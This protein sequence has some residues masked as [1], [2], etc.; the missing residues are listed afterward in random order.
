MIE[1]VIKRMTEVYNGPRTIVKDYDDVL[2]P[3]RAANLQMPSPSNPGGAP[4]VI[5]VDYP[6]VEEVEGLKRDGFYDLADSG[7]D[8]DDLGLRSRDDSRDEAKRQKDVMS[9][10]QDDTFPTDPE[11]RTMTRYLCFDVYDLDGDGVPEDVI[12]W[13]LK[14]DKSLLKAIALTELFPSDP[15]RRPLAETSFLPVK[16]R[17][18]GI[19]LPEL[20]EGTH[21]FLKQTLDQGMDGGTLATTPFFFYRAASSLKPEVLRPWPGDGIPLSDPQRD[22]NFPQ[23]PFDGSFSL[24][25]FALGKQQQERLTLVG[26]LQAGRV[27]QG[28]SSALRTVGGINTILAQGEARPE[29]VLRRF[30]MGFAEIF[31]QMH[32]LNQ[33]FFP[34][35]KQ[36][37]VLGIVEPGENPYPKIVRK[38]HLAGRFV[39]DFRASILNSSKVARQQGLEQLMGMLI[40]PIMIQL[41]IVGPDQIFRMV[42]DFV[43]STANDPTRYL[44]EPTPGAGKQRL[45]ANEAIS[46]IFDHMMPDGVP[47][48]PSAKDH[49]DQLQGF[50]QDDRFGLF[51]QSQLELFRIWLTQIAQLSI[52]EQGQQ[53][54]AQLAEGFQKKQAAGANGEATPTPVDQAAPPVNAN[55]LTD[56]TLPGAGGGANQ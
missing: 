24:N 32:E 49:L 38:E 56:E 37:R 20:M 55:E 12:F 50:M 26:D 2:V 34:E 25:A 31:K 27:P 51:D 30:F 46:I 48:E 28:K 54:V 39:W 17:H 13:V 11:H 10:V 45:T 44:Q 35:E 47:A 40:N 9:G 36:I 29:R 7:Q 4:H 21:D 33:H 22:I 23:I 5:L 42:H 1:M 53:E 16:G 18:E 15:P 19:S 6:T 14:E 3:P 43:Q 52:S 8:E 41:G